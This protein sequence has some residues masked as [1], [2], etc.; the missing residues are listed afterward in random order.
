LQHGFV[1]VLPDPFDVKFLPCAPAPSS[2]EE[3]VFFTHKTCIA[4]KDR[5]GSQAVP[6]IDIF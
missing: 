1:A 6:F 5:P 4:R 3:I 2:I